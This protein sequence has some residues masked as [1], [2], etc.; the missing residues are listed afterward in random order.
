MQL[1]VKTIM[2]KPANTPYTMHLAKKSIPLIVALFALILPQPAIPQSSS[3]GKIR[4]TY[5]LNVA[6]LRFARIVLEGEFSGDQY[7]VDVSARSSSVGRIAR[8]KGVT[9]SIGSI[10]TGEPLPNRYALDYE[11][12][13]SDRQ[14]NFNFSEGN[15]TN[16]SVDPPRG[17]SIWRESL[18][19]EHY[20][21]VTDPVS[22]FLFPLGENSADGTQACNR[23]NEV[24]DGLRRYELTMGYIRT[25]SQP[26]FESPGQSVPVYVCSFKY[27]PIVGHNTKDDSDMFYW[28]N[29]EGV[30]IWLMPIYA[31]DVLL[32]IRGIFPT[33]YG[34][35]IF[36]ANTLDLT[37]FAQQAAASQ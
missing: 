37:G 31:A 35:A 3:Q 1:S 6:R 5:Q 12:A 27:R 36:K 9:T 14:I 34:R 7:R 24:F 26:S 30:E 10:A 11:I 28:A 19:P 23:A 2:P 18:R 25:I 8:F 17:L 15:A 16:V 4:I 29:H 13:R 20:L 22:A 32:P 33:P 21:N